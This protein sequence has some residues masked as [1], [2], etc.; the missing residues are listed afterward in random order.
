MKKILL[1]FG[2]RVSV[3]KS[4]ALLIR[5]FFRYFEK[6]IPNFSGIA[7]AINAAFCS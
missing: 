6:L 5:T 4:L 7:C 1:V 2:G 3:K